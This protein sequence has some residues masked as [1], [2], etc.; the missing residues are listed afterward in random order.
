MSQRLLQE[1][2]QQSKQSIWLDNLSRPL[3][4]SDELADLLASGLRGLTSNPTI[5][6]R[7]LQ[8]SRAYQEQLKK[9]RTQDLSTEELYWELVLED[10]GHAA[11][12]LH[13]VF[14]ES[15]GSDGYVSIEVDPRLAHDA[16][17]SVVQAK[18]LHSRLEQPN[19][20]IK[21]PATKA[22]LTAIEELTAAGLSINVTLIFSLERYK[23]VLEAY[24]SGLEQ[25]DSPATIHSVAS[26]FISRLDAAIDSQVDQKLQG[27]TAIALGTQ[28]YELLKE[29]AQSERWQT[30]GRAGAHLQRLLW[31]STGVKNENYPNTMY[32]DGLPAAGTVITLPPDTLSAVIERGSAS[33]GS[34]SISKAQAAETL[35]QLAA[36]GVDI[37]KIT[38]Q[39]E[40]D[41]IEQ[42]VRSINSPLAAL[43]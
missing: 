20:M 13:P 24:L 19:V 33:V 40:R 5:F 18:D 8:D 22:G 29:T 2:Y 42:F 4:E 39:L 27:K 11:D 35:D 25:A 32:V 26:F 9:L 17:Q 15:G 16:G 14:E 41:G 30:L 37:N 7:A 43:K 23:A 36:N 12:M 31:A 6:E 38:T 3:L 10:V 28:A 21:I 1:I 34:Q